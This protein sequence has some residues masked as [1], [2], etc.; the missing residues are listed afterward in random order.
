MLLDLRWHST[1]LLPRL[2]PALRS[3]L[4]LQE[5]S[6]MLP[7][8]RYEALLRVLHHAILIWIVL[9][10]LACFRVE[11]KN[12]PGRSPSAAHFTLARLYHPCALYSSS[13]LSSAFTSRNE[14][15]VSTCVSLLSSALLCSSASLLLNSNSLYLLLFALSLPACLKSFRVRSRQRSSLA[16]PPLRVSCCCCVQISCIL[17]FI[18]SSCSRLVLTLHKSRPH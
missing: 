8:Q 2:L 10:F 1:Q 17:F 13:F 5:L 6:I 11:K 9:H 14:V 4:P 7:N 18:P 16:T 12:F 15:N 3:F